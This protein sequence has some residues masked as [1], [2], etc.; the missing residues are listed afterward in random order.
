MISYYHVFNVLPFPGSLLLR[1]LHGFFRHSCLPS[2]G[3]FKG[4]SLWLYCL[5]WGLWDGS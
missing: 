2:F 1:A 5:L 3:C 4:F